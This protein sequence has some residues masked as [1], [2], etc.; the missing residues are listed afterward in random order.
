M[1]RV[2]EIFMQVLPIF[3]FPTTIVCIDDDDMFLDGLRTVLDTKYNVLTYNNSEEA[4]MELKEYRSPVAKV[5]FLQSLVEH[6][7]Y[8]APNYAP[9]NLNINYLY[10]LAQL[11]DRAQEISILIIDYHMKEMDGLELCA[12][13]YGAPFKKILLTG[14]VDQQRAINAFNNKL[15]DGFIT[16]SDINLL[17]SLTDS[18]KFLEDQYFVELTATLRNNLEISHVLPLSDPIFIKFFTNWIQENDIKEYYLI[19]KNGSFLTINTQNERSYFIVHTDYS[20]N[21]LIQLYQE[22]KQLAPFVSSIEARHKIPFFGQNLRADQV[23][24]TLWGNYLYTPE[25][26]DG[27][28]R[29][30]WCNITM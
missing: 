11:A 18:I 21:G 28:E 20:L 1:K 17:K 7:Y 13:L 24:P 12:K 26:L 2:R 14:V 29:Y 3:Y 27:R 9:I 30:Y 8:D 10:Q 19:D 16:K 25:L 22:D 6:E 4:L 15:I 5:S 23:A